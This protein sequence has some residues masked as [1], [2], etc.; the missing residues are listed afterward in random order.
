MSMNPESIEQSSVPHSPRRLRRAI[1]AAVIAA[2]LIIAIQSIVADSD[3]QVA[4]MV[5]FIIG[6]F[7]TIYAFLQAH[8]FALHR[9]HRYAIPALA[10][11]AVAVL[12]L[13]VRFDGFSGELMPQFAFRF[14][15]VRELPTITDQSPQQIADPS[16]RSIALTDSTGFLGNNRSGVIA[17]REFAIPQSKR[18]VTTLW[19]QPIGEGWSS[20]AVAGDRAVT[21][22]QRAKLECVTC[23]QLGTGQLLWMRTHE[24]RHVNALGG[25]GPRSTPTI[26]DGRA[27]AQGAT[28]IVDCI[29]V[30]SGDLIWS[31]DLLS[32]AGWDKL[33]SESLITWG[34]A[35]SPLIVDGLCVVPFGGPDSMV[36]QGKSLIALSAED[37]STRW[38]TGKGQISYASPTVMTL[39]DATQ[40]VSVNEASVTGHA[41]EDGRQLWEFEWAGQSNGGANCASAVPAGVNRFL[42]GKGYGG[43]SALVEVTSDDGK[44]SA[45]SVWTSSN[46]LKTKF[47]H[48]CIQDGIAY[49]ISNGSLEAVDLGTEEVLWRQP[50]NERFGQG[51]LLLVGDL[52]IGQNESGEVVFVDADSE[53]YTVRLRLPAMISKTWNIPTIAGRHLLVRNDRQAFCFLLPERK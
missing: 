16:P 19:D 33:E 35:G 12:S 3:H 25:I 34:R 43:G 36:D 47:T 38:T 10:A 14:A 15:S 13:L 27:Y 6:L 7:A 52:L 28:G 51:Q 11:I 40:I 30:L 37:G 32:L 44:F 46:I 48:A 5:C 21:L 22:E 1:I 2:A 24:A 17:Q 9:D 26:H 29:D 41:I 53:K 39:A 4:N 8:L 45:E 23:Y 18:E 49:G 50:R 42:V 20:F 31:V